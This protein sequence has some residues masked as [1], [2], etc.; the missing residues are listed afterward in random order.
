[1]EELQRLNTRG[2]AI[3][4]HI[5]HGPL[6]LLTNRTADLEARLRSS[7]GS[8]STHGQPLEDVCAEYGPGHEIQYIS[9]IERL[10]WQDP[11]L[12]LFFLGIPALQ[13]AARQIYGDE[14][15]PVYESIQYRNRGEMQQIAWHRDMIV[16]MGEQVY[17]AGLHLDPARAGDGALRF[18]PKSHLDDAPD[19]LDVETKQSVAVETNAGELTLHN[20]MLV[21]CSDKMTRLP[22]RRTLYTEFRSL[23]L[24]RKNPGFPEEWII[25]KRKL[26]DCASEYYHR[27]IDNQEFEPLSM[28]ETALTEAIYGHRPRM[29]PAQYA[30][31]R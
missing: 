27:V 20:A 28:T 13:S 11:Q 2:Y 29:E 8:P 22:R 10:L 7:C 9:R 5:D 25:L 31:I 23:R 12:S 15:I 30:M 19:G 3:I 18:S 24:A 1:M 26:F 6:T 17:V 14:M 4:D 21:H 16:E